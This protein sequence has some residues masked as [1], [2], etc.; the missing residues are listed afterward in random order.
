[1]II[2][3]CSFRICPIRPFSYGLIHYFHRIST[4]TYKIGGCFLSLLNWAG[5][6]DLIVTSSNRWWDFGGDAY[7]VCINSEV[8]N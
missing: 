6:A 8:L 1:M 2:L 4:K 3:F 7:V 5:L